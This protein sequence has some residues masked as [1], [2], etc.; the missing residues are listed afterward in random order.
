M[1]PMPNKRAIGREVIDDLER[2]INLERIRLHETKKR[3]EM[4]SRMKMRT[5][6]VTTTI[7]A[8]KRASLRENERELKSGVALPG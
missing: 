5:K 1:K 4:K 7:G 3:L 6:I 2:E 8:Q